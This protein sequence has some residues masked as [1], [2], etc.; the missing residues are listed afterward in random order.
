MLNISIHL[1]F[2][3]T[4]RAR[5]M[6]NCNFSWSEKKFKSR[7]NIPRPN[8]AEILTLG[9]TK[10]PEPIIF[11]TMRQTPWRREISCF[12]R[13]L[14]PWDAVSSSATIL[15]NLQPQ[16]REG[17]SGET[18]REKEGRLVPRSHRN[19]ERTEQNVK[20]GVDQVEKKGR[21]VTGCLR[22]CQAHIAIV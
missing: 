21:S 22:L 17:N 15:S 6:C 7:L 9:E 16:L 12:S 4:K 13:T 2:F 11:P 8:K 5:N 10:M 3:K 14:L 18:G 20:R 19:R 1:T